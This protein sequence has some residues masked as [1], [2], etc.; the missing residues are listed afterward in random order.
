MSDGLTYKVLCRAE[1]SPDC[2]VSWAA[3]G[4]VAT[5]PP[6]YHVAPGNAGV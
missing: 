4:S 5:C 1:T 2:R 6:V 3:R